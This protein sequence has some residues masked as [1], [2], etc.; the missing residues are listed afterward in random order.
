MTVL[1][2]KGYAFQKKSNEEI[3][4]MVHQH[5]HLHIWILC[6]QHDEDR[7]RKED[8]YSCMCAVED[9][10]DPEN[11]IEI[12]FTEMIRKE[13][14]DDVKEYSHIRPL[15]FETKEAATRFATAHLFAKEECFPVCLV[16]TSGELFGTGWFQVSEK[17]SDREF[18]DYELMIRVMLG[19]RKETIRQILLSKEHQRSLLEKQ[20]M[21]LQSEINALKKDNAIID[22]IMVRGDLSSTSITLEED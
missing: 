3:E 11:L 1:Y 18:S 19:N 9:E 14:E 17:S 6:G 12:G 8:I 22:C 21:Y 13:N 16:P 2:K 4:T 7:F 20:I 5:Y 10:D 15:V